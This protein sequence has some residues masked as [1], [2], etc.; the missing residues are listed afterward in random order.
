M[1]L[2][3]Y[4]LLPSSAITAA[5]VGQF[6]GTRAQEICVCRGGTRLELLRVDANSGKLQLV[7]SSE[8]F[9]NIRSIAPFKLTGAT[10]GISPASRSLVA[11]N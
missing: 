4:S 2:L 5:C 6:S 1:H 10:K 11:P 8:V 9:G 7:I 3:N